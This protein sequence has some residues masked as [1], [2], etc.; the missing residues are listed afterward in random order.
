M[1]IA[2]IYTESNIETKEITLENTALLTNALWIDLLNPNK[3]EEK[4]V[5]QYL[6]FDVPSKKEMQEIELSSRLYSENNA[7]FMTATMVARSDSL[8]P[9]SDAVTFILTSNTLITVRYI[10][11]Q[12]FTIFATR[13][14]RLDK[15]EYTAE[16]LLLGLLEAAVDRL[17]DVLEKVIHQLDRFSQMAFRPKSDEKGA[18]QLDYKTLLQ[19]IGA[20]EDLGTKARESLLSINLLVSYLG[21]AIKSKVDDEV[22]SRLKILTQDILS[23]SDHVTFSSSKASFL[24]NATLGMVNIEQSNI[25]KI[26]SVAAVLFLPPTLIA[27]IYGMNFKL[28]P[29]LNW[30]LGYPAVICFMILSAWLSYKYFKSRKWL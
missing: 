10:E 5:E 12:A 6:K 14:S 23:L 30:S 1:I 11:P 24:L 4:L 16:R 26:L 22:Q 9:K 21:G 19:D 2:H 29:E 20:N 8:A 13:L 18:S 15:K 27:S 7:L 17:A 25:I 3:E 28:M